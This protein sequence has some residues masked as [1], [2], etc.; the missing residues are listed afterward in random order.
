MFRTFS[1]P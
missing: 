1:L